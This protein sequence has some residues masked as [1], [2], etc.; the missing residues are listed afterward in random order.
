MK[1]LK[2]IMLVEDEADIQT[3]AK[4]ALEI[5]GG[6]QVEICGLGGEALIKAKSFSPDLILLDVMMPDMDGLSVIKSLCENSSTASIPIIFMTARMQSQDVLDYDQLGAIG[7][8]AKPFD[9]MQL[10]ATVKKIWEEKG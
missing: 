7:F 10:S 6:F 5:T 3:V 9:P 8:I 2:K 1:P 4:M